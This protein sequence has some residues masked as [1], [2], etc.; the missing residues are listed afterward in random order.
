MV[1]PKHINHHCPPSGFTYYNPVAFIWWSLDT[2]SMHMHDRLTY[3]VWYENP[4]TL[5]RIRKKRRR[6]VT[7][8]KGYIFR[9]F[10][11]LLHYCVRTNQV[12]A[13]DQFL[14]TTK[15]ATNKT[16]CLKTNKKINTFF[17][18]GKEGTEIVPVCSDVDAMCLMC[19]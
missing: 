18:C 13:N 4:V 19:N 14:V 3:I 8:I 15:L 17:Y 12:Q 7:A 9:S 16:I 10:P 6:I 1:H 5:S 2:S 11:T